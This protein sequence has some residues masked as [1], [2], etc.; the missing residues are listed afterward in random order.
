MSRLVETVFPARLGRS[1]RWLVASSWASNLGDGLMMAAGPLLVASQTHNPM[2]V[3]G[4]AW[5]PLPWLLFGLVAGALADRLD[6]RLMVM[7]MDALRAIV[8][9]GLCVVIVT[10][11]VNIW[12]VL[13][14]MF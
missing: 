8:L 6:R 10:G 9:A 7:V 1:F 13:V 12:L 4:A 5:P 14:A 11:H 2:L 3:A